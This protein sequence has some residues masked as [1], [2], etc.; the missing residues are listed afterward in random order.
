M[1]A[2]GFRPLDALLPRAS[3]RFG[4]KAENLAALVRGGFPV[5]AGY[6][7]SADLASAQFAR[8]LPVSLRPDLLWGDA[9]VDPARLAEARERVLSA[10]LAADL[11]EAL[12]R[13]LE[14]LRS[15]AA[16]G[17]A[18]RCSPAFE[19]LANASAAGLLGSVLHVCSPDAL[20]DAVRR[21]WAAVFEPRV[22]SYLRT[23]SSQHL[24][25]GGI[26]V[27]LQ[28]LVPADV[29][30]V[31]FTVN[32]LT[33][34][35]DEIVIE[36]GYGLGSAA[37]EGTL[38]CDVY[39]I[40][41]GTGR[42]RDR[43]IG[44]KRSRAVP[45][46]G[47]GVVEEVVEA[48][49]AGQ[50]AL[51]ER[52]LGQVLALGQRIEQHFGDAR[53]VEFAIAG[54]R[55]YVLGAR[56]VTGVP[57]ARRR[58]TAAR[59]AR[60][61][62]LDPAEIVWSSVNV[63][64]ALPGVATPLTWSVLSDFSEIGFRRAFAAL[65]CTVP[66]D[67]VLV[68]SFRGRIY[69]NLSEL[70]RI[71]AQ[72]P[73]FRPSAVL[74]LAGAAEVERLERSVAGVSSAGFLA[75][76]PATAARY[77][78]T[79][80]RFRAGIRRFER[81]FR[82]E[83]ARLSGF[84]L[85]ILP[86]PSLGETLADARRL[87]EATGATMLTAYGGLLSVLV[88]MRAGLRTAVGERAEQLSQDVLSGVEDVDSAAPGLALLD[89]AEAFAQDE[90]ARAALVE[91]GA[92]CIEDLPDG[93]ARGAIE[94]FLREHGH[95]GI[96][97]AELT[98]PRWREAP[99]MLFDVLRLHVVASA[100]R[101]DATSAIAARVRGPRDRS[102]RVVD[103][104][105]GALRP[106]LRRLIVVVR[107][108]VRERE[109]LRSHV[110]RVLGL[111]REI[112]L[113]AS[114]RLRAREQDVGDDAAFLLTLEELHG[115]LGGDV[116][117]VGALVA[118]RRAQIARDR[119]LPDPPDTFVGYPPSVEA[120]VV[121]AERLAGLG[122][123]PGVVEGEARVLAT[124]A[125]IGELRRDEILVVPT[126]D[127]GWAPA[128]LGVRA[129]V[130]DRGGP[131]S[132]ACIVAREYGLPAVVNLRVATRVLRSGDRI[133]VDGDAGTIEILARR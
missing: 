8:V 131:L 44:H 122:A 94:R 4:S 95:R 23:L 78:A 31:L 38:G 84:D 87:L 85:R 91:R 111:L 82:A 24:A 25:S 18:V 98:E 132:H 49:R 10:P 54:D 53:D 113:E 69:L 43:V 28:A 110:V 45:R 121:P 29:S 40:D 27:V 128:F 79:H 20:G 125:H 107:H 15:E 129:L 83:F 51:D 102:E 17:V 101:A 103:Q 97:E 74:P 26:G 58:T 52:M 76:L 66:K 118:R 62:G 130:T 30:G 123:S 19:G 108:Y 5:P 117:A 13:A 9:N 119:A 48:G 70:V 116:R 71:G 99:G 47:G 46:S 6:A 80:V 112:G 1:P 114:R 67:A 72:V 7:L 100:S 55:L 60:G 104:A 59:R 93:D 81:T 90:P 126:A 120:P 39:R 105:P 14:A 56:P 35:P 68:G 96:R 34:D 88:L 61:G 21:S 124:P 92:R 2:T 63:G 42:L 64:E 127:V 16:A 37:T 77:V 109:R 11:V 3:A 22:A 73:G 133:R 41:K 65:G 33:A 50:Q 36:A 89:V 57:L 86:G 115:V 12:A 106:L 32:P 75:R